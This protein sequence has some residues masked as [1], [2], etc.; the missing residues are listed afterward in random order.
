M[1]IYIVV[2]RSG[3]P[4][5]LEGHLVMHDKANYSWTLLLLESPSA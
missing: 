3:V 4:I 2:A 1:S 5:L